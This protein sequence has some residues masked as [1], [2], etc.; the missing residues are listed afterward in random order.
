MYAV[1]VLQNERFNSLSYKTYP[2]SI[3]H[4]FLQLPFKEHT[5]KSYNVTHF[6]VSL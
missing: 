4:F 1:F 5:K 3:L 6:C 2:K